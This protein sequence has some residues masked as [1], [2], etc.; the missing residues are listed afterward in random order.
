MY[1]KLL[2]AVDVPDKMGYKAYNIKKI[3]EYNTNQNYL[4]PKSLVITSHIFDMCIKNGKVEVERF[5]DLYLDNIYEEVVS[6]F[7][8]ISL[9]VRSSSTVEDTPI[10]SMAGVYDSFLNVNSKEKFFN[11]VISCFNSVYN[12]AIQH[13]MEN[14][15]KKHESG[16][17]AILIQEMV[18]DL[19][20][21]GVAFT[22]NPIT[23]KN[24]YIIEFANNGVDV[25]SG[26][27]KIN[28]IQVQ[29]NY[30][31]NDPI[32]NK[33][34]H[35]SKELSQKFGYP[36]DIEWGASEN[37]IYIF[38]CRPIISY[39]LK[40]PDN[41]ILSNFP[42]IQG[43]P[44]SPGIAF[45]K[46]KSLNN[47]SIM[48]LNSYNEFFKNIQGVGGAILTQGGI[49]SHQANLLREHFIPAVMLND[50]LEINDL[51][52]TYILV[53]GFSGD[54]FIFN[55]LDNY[56]KNDVFNYYLSYLEINSTIQNHLLINKITFL[57]LK[58]AVYIDINEE[59]I[60]KKLDKFNNSSENIFQ[61]I[62]NCDLIEN[63][64]Q[65]LVDC[66]RIQQDKNVRIQFKKILINENDYRQEEQWVLFFTSIDIAKKFLQKIGLHITQIQYRNITRYEKNKT[67]L[68]FIQWP[69][70]P[71][72]LGVEFIEI[73]DFERLQLDISFLESPAALT[74]EQIFSK[75]KN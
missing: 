7:G 57:N 9:I 17:M 41:Q 19:S 71:V 45:G 2:G 75:I 66:I 14:Y 48:H 56:R 33:L 38:Q 11:A 39:H 53:D 28:R 15:N 24:E 52:D 23:N 1:T 51:D 54:I 20:I 3:N 22:E 43:T 32:I 4:V 50:S 72:Y 62:Y 6:Y 16:K 12:P 55:Q 58:E 10:F 44:V 13:M 25:V 59:E 27:G 46:Y 34:V 70:S 35:I 26:K 47:E 37:Q 42:K 64:I 31:V 40:Q 30:T 65:G 67:I 36:L 61:T 60:Y 49:L 63:D 74:G 21:A 69:N 29:D 8:D 73:E 5:R 18:K 68:N